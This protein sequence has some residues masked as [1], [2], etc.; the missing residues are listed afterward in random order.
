MRCGRTPSINP[1]NWRR[2]TPTDFLKFAFLGVL[3]I[4]LAG[5]GASLNLVKRDDLRTSSLSS[6]IVKAFTFRSGKSSQV[7]SRPGVYPPIPLEAN[8]PRV[9]RFLREYV[10]EHRNT[11]RN[12]LG[13][14]Q[15]FLPMVKEQTQKHHLPQEL[16]YLFYLNQAWPRSQISRKRV[17]HVAIYAGDCTH[18]RTTCRQFRG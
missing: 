9:R 18:L 1:E 10:Y 3:L 7:S 14:A 4:N 15:K 11:T 17:G 16:A 2:S 13:Q 8:E 6:A 5:C 12:Y